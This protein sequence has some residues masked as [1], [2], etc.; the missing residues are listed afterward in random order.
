LT[1]L[2]VENAVRN[3]A[4]VS[5][6]GRATR[7]TEDALIGK[8]LS[9]QREFFMALVRPYQRT[10]YAMALS[11]SRNKEDAEDIVQSALL[12]ALSR[13]SQFRRESMFGTWLVQIT[14]NEVRMRRRKDR[15]IEML[16]LGFTPEDK[17]NYVPKDFQDWRE[18]PSEALERMEIRET[19]LRALAS[20]AERY[21]EAFV[22]RDVHDLSIA[23]TATIL[24]IS[25]GAVKTRLHRARLM[26]REILAPGLSENGRLAWSTR[27]AQKPWE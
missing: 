1:P 24:G 2:G 26:L 9:G 20:I 13:L 16:S 27:E 7:G 22:L 6:Q 4:G 19:L 8:I 3:C 12:K 5:D 17:T 23:D 25:R 21:R 14:I 18:I 10:V 11:L 15:R